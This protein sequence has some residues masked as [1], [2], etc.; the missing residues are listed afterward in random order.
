MAGQIFTAL[1]ESNVNVDMI[2]QNEPVSDGAEADMSF[3]V[4]RADLRAA[5][6]ALA[7][8]MSEYGIRS[9]DDPEMGKVSIVGAGMRSHPGVAAKVFT[10]LGERGI[11][12]EMISTSPIKISCVVRADQLPEAVRALHEAFGL[13]AEDVKAEHPFGRG[14]ADA[15]RR[16]GRHRRR[17]DRHARQ[18]ARARVPGDEIVPFASERSAGRELEGFGTIQPLSD[19]T[20]QGFDIAIFSA[21]AT[22]S[23][24]W[25][26]RFVD[27]GATVVDN[28]SAF[29]QQDDVPL[30]VAEVNPEA[31]DAHQ[32]IIANPNCSTMELMLPAKAIHAAAG[33]ERL[34]VSTYQCVSGTGVKA[35][36]ELEAQSRAALAGEPL[37]E[38]QI[39]PHPIAFNVLGGA[40]NFA[41]GDDYTD[42]ERKMMFETRK[43]LGDQDIGISV[44]CARV[45]GHLLALTV[46]QPADARRAVGRGRARCC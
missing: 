21:G 4:P 29:R 17:R 44:T 37:P 9:Q 10:T 33:I 5:H 22:T 19:E 7:P 2:I 13:G 24:A 40:G 20:I 18:A 25:A 36:E 39:Y 6:E 14:A 3:T 35:V 30:V 15:G 43:I 45:P 46:G 26:P 8:V 38:P 34:I 42:E 23:R 12:I 41:E 27:A 32:G 28:S 11:N 16:G 31:L 1:A